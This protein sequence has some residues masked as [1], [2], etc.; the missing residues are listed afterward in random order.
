MRNT[1]ARPFPRMQRVAEMADGVPD[2]LVAAPAVALPTSRPI[3]ARA[4][5]TGSLAPLGKL[6]IQSGIFKR[7]SD[8]EVSVTFLGIVGDHQGDTKHHGGLE[9]AVHHYAF[10]HYADWIKET[11]E[12]AV[13]L[14]REGAFGENISTLGM[15]EANVCIGDIYRFGSAVLE[16]SQARQPCWR[17]NE[18]FGLT[19]MA[20]RV[21][22]TGRTGWYYRVKQE[23]HFASGVAVELLDRPHA[24]WPLRRILHAFYRDTLNIGE[25]TELVALNPL[26]ASW[27]ELAR[28]RMERHA[29]E[30]WSRR[31]NTP[32][33]VSR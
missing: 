26:T 12:L 5:L 27:R 1:Y 20:R 24:D 22:E 13:H 32:H 19:T 7:P 11:P 2:P 3:V 18:R 21:Q 30:D 33:P 4:V 17:L 31:L 8:R 23:G 25:L 16:V 15:T 9:K 14:N 6:G 29:I 28:R 10:E